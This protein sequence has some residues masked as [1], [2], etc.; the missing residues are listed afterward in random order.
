VLVQMR[1]IFEALGADVKWDGALERITARRGEM[2]IVM[3][4]NDPRAS[5]NGSSRRLEVPPRLV[6]GTTRV[7]LRFVAAAFGASVTY[8]GDRVRI[9]EPGRKTILVYLE[10]SGGGVPPGSSGRPGRSSRP[11]TP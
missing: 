2:A 4:I 5:V 11:P 9:E 8:L 6:Y 10:G 3:R 7:P 1:P